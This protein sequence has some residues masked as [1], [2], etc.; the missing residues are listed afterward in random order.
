MIGLSMISTPQVI[1]DR[2][3]RF[4]FNPPQSE[5]ADT[6][7]IPTGQLLRRFGP[8][9]RV[10]PGVAM[11]RK[12]VGEMS[13]IGIGCS[14]AESLAAAAKVAGGKKCPGDWNLDGLLSV[15]PMR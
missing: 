9:D 5:E 8:S 1:L 10:R 11:G 7:A 12:Y 6:P 2:R 4:D 3:A 13:M 15:A 14:F